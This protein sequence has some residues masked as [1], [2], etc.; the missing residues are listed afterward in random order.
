[1]N[2]SPFRDTNFNP[3]MFYRFKESPLGSGFF[4][5]DVGFEHESNGQ[6]VSRSRSW[7]L[8]HISPFFRTEE[9]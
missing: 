8:L 3:E 9:W 4:G 6:P 1:M 7:N 2:S 5:A